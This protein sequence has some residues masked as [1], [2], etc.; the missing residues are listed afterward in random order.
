MEDTM[1]DNDNIITE[2]L[3]EA[4]ME[5]LRVTLDSIRRD[6]ADAR[7]GVGKII[8]TLNESNGKEALT[9][10]IARNDLYIQR[11]ES[12]NVLQVIDAAKK[13]AVKIEADKMQ[14]RTTLLWGIGLASG[15]ALTLIKLFWP[16]G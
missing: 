4:R 10:T 7:E 11:L 9:A 2:A 14:R 6:T 3:C 1:Q 12:A 5:T 13:L 8:R 16:V 15:W